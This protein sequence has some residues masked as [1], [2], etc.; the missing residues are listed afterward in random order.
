MT[1]V[2]RMKDMQSDLVFAEIRVE[3]VEATFAETEE[4]IPEY[5]DYYY[6]YDFENYESGGFTSYGDYFKSATAT[7]A[8]GEYCNN[9]GDSSM[10]TTYGDPE[11]PNTTII[12]TEENGNKYLNHTFSTAS[13]SSGARIGTFP[14]GTKILANAVAVDFKFMDQITTWLSCFQTHKDLCS[15]T[16]IIFQFTAG[17]I[18]DIRCSGTRT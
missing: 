2:D 16:E 1:T 5:G 13:G 6:H 17:N 9:V 8:D 14:L 10:N 12:M 18:S 4:A 11:L 7:T 3:G 15:G